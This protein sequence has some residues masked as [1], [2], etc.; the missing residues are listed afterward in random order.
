[1]NSETNT[2]EVV[3]TNFIAGYGNLP[4]V[5]QIPF[6]NAVMKECGWN[7]LVTFHNKRRGLVRI[8]PPEIQ[9]LE[10][11]FKKFGINPWTGMP[12]FDENY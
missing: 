8:T 10:A 5:Q 7:S 11:H 3:K 12:F 6:K 1:M 2:A 9:I 4:A